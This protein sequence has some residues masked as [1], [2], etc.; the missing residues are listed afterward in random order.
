[1]ELL[2]IGMTTETGKAIPSNYIIFTENGRYLQHQ[3]LYIAFIPDG[4]RVILD[5]KYW[6]CDP[7]IA[8]CRD[9]FL[10]DT[11]TGTKRKIKT[12]EYLFGNL[13]D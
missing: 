10:N 2:K 7:V 13:Q 1:M 4:G 9:L 12:G 8:Y 11:I 6:D 5:E 3:N